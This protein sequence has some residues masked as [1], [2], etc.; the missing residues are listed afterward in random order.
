MDL[1]VS[2][3]V[4]DPA[5]AVDPARYTLGTRVPQVALRPLAREE[6]AEVLRWASRDRVARNRH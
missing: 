6:V 3:T 5:R 1:T 2:A 4:L